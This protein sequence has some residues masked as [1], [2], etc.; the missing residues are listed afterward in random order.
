MLIRSSCLIARTV[1][2]E[3]LRR[4]EIY[5]IVLVACSLIGAVMTLDFFDLPG[6]N[7]FYR[8]FALRA[9]SAATAITV[10]VLSSRQLPREFATRTIYPLLARPISR[11][12]FLF[13]KL[14][15]VWLAAVFCFALFMVVYV[16]GMLY[17]NAD[18][19]WV[20]FLQFVYLQLWM[21]LILATLGFLLSMLC[22]IDAAIT[23]GIL[24]YTMGATLSSMI[25][26]MY[27]E[28]GKLGQWILILLT[29][30]IPQLSLFDTSDRTVHAITWPP[31]APALLAQLSLYALIFSTVFFCGALVAFRRRAL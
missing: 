27:H 28:A 26:V 16:G 14:L 9:M 1:F 18:V 8:E 20:H 23:L 30:L 4:K 17:L 22:N 24:L 19:H 29:W 15:G 6:L 21:M 10:I 13:G 7:K 3:A 31:L 5:M 11:A 2:I 12:T 25:N